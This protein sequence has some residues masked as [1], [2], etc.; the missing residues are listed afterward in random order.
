[1]KQL[2]FKQLEVNAQIIRFPSGLK[3]S[4]RVKHC[5]SFRVYGLEK[6]EQELT[7]R[8]VPLENSPDVSA[9]QQD[10]TRKASFFEWVDEHTADIDNGTYLIPEEFLATEA[11]SYSTLGINRRANKPFDVVLGNHLERNNAPKGDLRWIKSKEALVDRLNNGTCVGCH[12][13]STTAGFHFLGEDD[14][15]IS[16]GNQSIDSALFLHISIAKSL[17]EKHKYTASSIPNRRYVS[18]TFF[19]PGTKTV[20]TNHSCILPEHEKDLQPDAQWNKCIRYEQ[21]EKVRGFECWIYFGQCMPS[22]ESLLAGNTCRTGVI[23]DSTKQSARVFQ[24]SFLCRC[25]CANTEI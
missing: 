15:T 11:L 3:P 20:S 16:G 17:A 5:I 24:P 6:S 9:I 4:L 13:A 1:M 21:C 12:Q 18:T 8:E 23:S 14:H 19:A 22:K 25:V 7:L 10:S 2:R